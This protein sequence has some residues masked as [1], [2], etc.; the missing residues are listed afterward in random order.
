[1]QLSAVIFEEVEVCGAIQGR[2]RN[3][4]PNFLVQISLGGAGV[5]HVK[6]WGPKKSVC[7]SKLKET[8]FLAGCPRDFGRDI[9]GAAR[10]VGEETKFVFKSCPLVC[11]GESA[12]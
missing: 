5:F 4:N 8:K 9:P 10:K 6:G 11:D 12:C 2:K 1:M 7:P 3:P